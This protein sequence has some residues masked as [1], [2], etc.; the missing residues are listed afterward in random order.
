MNSSVATSTAPGVT[1]THAPSGNHYVAVGYL[2]AFITAL[3]RIPAVA[4]VI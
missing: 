3:R 4:R 1:S 2:R